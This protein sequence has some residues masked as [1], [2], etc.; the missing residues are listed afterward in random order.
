MEAES[1]MEP[2]QRLEKRGNRLSGA[3]DGVICAWRFREGTDNRLSEFQKAESG[4]V[5][6]GHL[7]KRGNRSKGAAKA[8]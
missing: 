3:P 1:G 7:E 6:G 2:G 8:A 5:A 4:I